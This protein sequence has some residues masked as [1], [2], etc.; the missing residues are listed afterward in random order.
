MR[1]GI[2]IICLIGLPLFLFSMTGAPG[3][4]VPCTDCAFVDLNQDG[5][6]DLAV[7][8]DQDGLPDALEGSNS[9]EMRWAVFRGLPDSLEQ[10][11]SAFVNWWS[12]HQDSSPA[13]AWNSWQEWTREPVKPCHC[14]CKRC[15]CIH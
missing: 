12:T 14:G 3:P 6:N 10:D 5:I 2:I 7:D 1:A 11:S 4:E 9:L 13:A 15:R 8:Q